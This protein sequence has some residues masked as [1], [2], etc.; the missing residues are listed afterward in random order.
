MLFSVDDDGRLWEL[1]SLG[2][3]AYRTRRAG[4]SQWCTTN[5][6]EDETLYTSHAS[7]YV[8]KC[9]A[10]A[11]RVKQLTALIEQQEGA[12][13]VINLPNTD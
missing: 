8:D 4:D 12:R 13:R 3:G 7:A 5:V 9:I 11:K 1:E 10:L 6:A 2:D